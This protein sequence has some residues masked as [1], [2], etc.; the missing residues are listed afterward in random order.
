MTVYLV[1]GMLFNRFHKGASGV[2]VIPHVTF[3]K[4][5]PVYAKVGLLY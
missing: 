3:W 2:E 1:G 4:S 5:V